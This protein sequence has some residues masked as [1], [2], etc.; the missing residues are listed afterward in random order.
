MGCFNSGFG[1]SI[2]EIVTFKTPLSIL[3]WMLLISIF[4]GILNDL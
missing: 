4:S 3:A 1:S 2:F